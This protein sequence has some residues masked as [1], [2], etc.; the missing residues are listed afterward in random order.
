M[1]LLWTK[2]FQITFASNGVKYKQVVQLNTKKTH[3]N[4]DKKNDK[5]KIK[6]KN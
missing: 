4:D 1:L 6:T 2:V 5:K 3:G